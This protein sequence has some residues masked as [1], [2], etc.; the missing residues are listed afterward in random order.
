MQVQAINTSNNQR[1]FCA[2]S[3]ISTEKTVENFFRS[4]FVVKNVKK[5]PVD[6]E[7]MIEMN[8]RLAKTKQEFRSGSAQSLMAVRKFFYNT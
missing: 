5:V 7:E 1:S 4:K 8:K 3:A 6:V 2:K